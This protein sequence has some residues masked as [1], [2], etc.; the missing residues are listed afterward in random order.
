M[1]QAWRLVSWLLCHSDD[2][3]SIRITSLS[4][5]EDLE[6]LDKAMQGDRDDTESQDSEE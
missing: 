3:D 1:F 4:S 6:K 2:A 5:A